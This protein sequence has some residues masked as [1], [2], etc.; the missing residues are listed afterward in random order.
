MCRTD[1]KCSGSSVGLS[2]FVIQMGLK[3]GCRSAS[4]CVDGSYLRKTLPVNTIVPSNSA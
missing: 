4:K 2:H 3:G 1:L